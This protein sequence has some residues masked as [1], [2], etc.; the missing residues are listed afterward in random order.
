VIAK[1]RSVRIFSPVDARSICSGP[2]RKIKEQQHQPRSGT[3][4]AGW[5]EFFTIAH[6]D[7]RDSGRLLRPWQSIDIL[8][9]E[10]E[11]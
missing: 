2:S 6:P 5:L 3:F 7:A 10:R 4:I 1:L 11:C 8:E 9:I